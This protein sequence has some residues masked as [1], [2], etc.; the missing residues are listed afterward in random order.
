MSGWHY[1]E[2]DKQQHFTFV[3]HF[4]V[5]SHRGGTIGGDGDL[6]GNLVRQAIGTNGRDDGRPRNGQGGDQSGRNG[7][8]RHPGNIAGEISTSAAGT[9][10]WVWPASGSPISHQE[11]SPMVAKDVAFFPMPEGC[12]Q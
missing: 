4:H 11:W 9:Q 7:D 6:K 8:H 12:N 10:Q 3:I 2:L 5:V 1:Q